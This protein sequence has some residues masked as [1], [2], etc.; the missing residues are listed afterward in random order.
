MTIKWINVQDQAPPAR[1]LRL[2]SYHSG[3]KTNI[4]CIFVGRWEKANRWARDHYGNVFS[5][6][7][8]AHCN[9]WWAEMINL[10]EVPE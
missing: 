1:L 8:Y 6:M 5:S 2:F 3:A 7:P 10:P 4:P 9:L